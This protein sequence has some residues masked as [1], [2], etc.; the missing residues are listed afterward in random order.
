MMVPRYTSRDAFDADWFG[1]SCGAYALEALV[2]GDIVFSACA[3]PEAGRWRAW[4]VDAF[5]QVED[6]GVHDDLESARGICYE[7]AKLAGVAGRPES[8]LEELVSAFA[9]LPPELACRVADAAELARSSASRRA[10]RASESPKTR[11]R[12]ARRQARESPD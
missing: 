3:K 5:G 1:C 10:A 8:R 6:H 7:A 4:T 9:S 2:R 11:P 12:T